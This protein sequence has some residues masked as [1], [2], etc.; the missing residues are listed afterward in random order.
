M[1]LA[2]VNINTIQTAYSFLFLFKQE[3]IV[4]SNIF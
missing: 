4:G 2:Q 1:M 3:N